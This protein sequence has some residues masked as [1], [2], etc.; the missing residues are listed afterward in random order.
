MLYKKILLALELSPSDDPKLIQQAKVL[1]ANNPTGLY[2]IHSI[3][4]MSNYAIMPTGIDFE[5][6]LL[7]DAE[8]TMKTVGASLQVPAERQIVRAGS[9]K[10]VILEEAER[11]G[12]DLIVL[13]SHGRHGVRLLLGS[14]A[15]SILQSAKCDVLAV[16]VGG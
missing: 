8:K 12:A 5:A 1:V 16:R 7:K 13:G 4:Y 10:F 3:E 15:N 6:A 2:L 14:T 9:A 11:I